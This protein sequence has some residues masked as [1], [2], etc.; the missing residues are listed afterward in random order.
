[1]SIIN[2]LENFKLEKINTPEIQELKSSEIG[3]LQFLKKVELS[4]KDLANFIEFNQRT[5]LRF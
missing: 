1:M 5:Q 2:K 3:I 4:T